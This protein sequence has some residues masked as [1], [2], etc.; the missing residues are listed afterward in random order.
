MAGEVIQE[1]K[2]RE[3]EASERIARAHA[4]A[5]KLLEKTRGAK[6]DLIR[7]KDVLLEKEEVK[8][9][10]RYAKETE[11]MVKQIEEE[12]KSDIQKLTSACEKNVGR[13][14]VFIVSEIVK[15]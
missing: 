1:I 7:E 12:E 3:N 11:N 2:N 8:I 13:V 15:E 10:D 5:K 4:D 6:A 9:R 14:V